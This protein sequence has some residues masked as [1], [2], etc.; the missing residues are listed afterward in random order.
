MPF[1]QPILLT[2]NQSLKFSQKKFGDF[3]KLKFFESDIF[4]LQPHENQLKV[5]GYQGW[6]EI[7]IITLV[8][9][10]KSPTPNI[11]APSVLYVLL[12][13]NFTLFLGQCLVASEDLTHPGE[14]H[15]YLPQSRRPWSWWILWLVVLRPWTPSRWGP[16]IFWIPG[17]PGIRISRRHP[18]F[19][20]QLPITSHLLSIYYIQHA[21][22]CDGLTTTFNFA[23]FSDRKQKT[24]CLLL[25]HF[26]QGF[27]LT[28]YYFLLR[29]SS[30]PNLKTPAQ[31]TKKKKKKKP[32]TR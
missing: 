15:L 28:T 30:L 21:K 8:S 3:E 14:V 16:G 6:A 29:I 12:Y 31:K 4:L 18:Y 26:L 17:Y 27:F 5:L 10:Q 13:L 11:S 20:P 25:V 22:I 32:P 1:D 7:L 9:S 24:K 23:Q 2:N 19:R